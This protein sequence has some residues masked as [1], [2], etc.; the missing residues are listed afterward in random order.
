MKGHLTL[1]T[2]TAP[3]SERTLRTG[4]IGCGKIAP[5]HAAALASLP[6]SQFVAT[7][8]GLEG[9][10]Q[11]MADQYGAK[12]AFLDYNELLQSGEVDALCVLKDLKCV[13]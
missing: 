10:A 1:V 9:R 5:N 6:E 11:A 3:K 7:C 12:L 2:E 4:I 13:V 8:D